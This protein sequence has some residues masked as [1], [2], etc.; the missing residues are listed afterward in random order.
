M[1]KQFSKLFILILIAVFFTTGLSLKKASAA[2]NDNLNIAAEGALLVDAQSG[3]ILYQK[4]PDESLHPAS[5][6]KMMTEYLVLEAIKNK[7][8]AWD[9]LTAISDY[10][11][12]ISQDRNLSNVPLR[13]DQQY[14][15]KELYESMAIYSAN[16]SAIALAELVSG[17]EANFVKMMNDK[18]AQ[19]GLK[20]YKFVNCTG[21]NN[22]DLRGMHPAGGPTDENVMS[23]RSVA[24]LA[25]RLLQDYPEVLNT[26][27]IPKTVFR[28]GT[29]DRIEMPNWNW[30]LPGSPYASLSYPGVDGLK[31]GS[32][33]LGGFSFT[34][35]AK[36]GD[37]R[38]LSVVMKTD[39]KFARFNETKK[40]LDYGF[41]NYSLKEIF[42]AGYKFSS[43][44]TL[45][46]TD[47]VEETVPIQS[48]KPYLMAVKTGEENQFDP[49][50]SLAR[51]E[52][53]KDGAVTAPV[54]K[55]QVLGYL[56]ANF[57]GGDNYGFISDNCTEKIS[58][59]ASSD[60]E[61]AGWFTLFFR[62]I[63]K[64]F[65]NLFK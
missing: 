13:K 3:R 61:K 5:M 52:S 42:P 14:S 17:S 49:V 36:K 58:M 21:L 19:L 16:A 55:G 6:T 45:P 43:Q 40:L 35:T 44:Q 22:A 62:S 48:E 60:D 25:F 30:M 27:S 23:P 2:P 32:T 39:D 51:S 24:T 1:R 41:K 11:Y 65:Q 38:L 29:T 37:M 28:E 33:D 12:T 54:K 15:V 50:F 7:K 57:K 64:F 34:C 18:A 53:V 56:S 4:N 9:Q 8:I 10:V 31:T 63:I 20:D 47:G 59:V 46:V 26:S